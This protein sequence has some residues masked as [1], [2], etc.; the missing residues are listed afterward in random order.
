MTAE[1]V[2]LRASQEMSKTGENAGRVLR[3]ALRG[4]QGRG[5]EDSKK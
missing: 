1:V 3:S 2:S 5:S 4:V